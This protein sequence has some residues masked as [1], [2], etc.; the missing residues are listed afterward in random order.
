MRELVGAVQVGRARVVRG[1]GRRRL[2][3]AVAAVRL[4]LDLAAVVGALVGLQV[5]VVLA[6]LSRGTFVEFCLALERQGA[7]AANAEAV[8]G[9][10]A[11]I[12]LKDLC[13]GCSSVRMA[14][15]FILSSKRVTYE[16]TSILGPCRLP[17]CRR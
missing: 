15:A 10:L 2:A 4:E 8:L 12:T 11:F 7:V 9:L 5:D 17:R 6:V 16:S 13:G 3:V 1:R 14:F